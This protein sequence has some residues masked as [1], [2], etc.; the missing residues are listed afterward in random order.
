MNEQNGGAGA[1]DEKGFESSLSARHTSTGGKRARRE[2]GEDGGEREWDMVV[3]PLT[4]CDGGGGKT[5]WQRL[6]DCLRI[7]EIPQHRFA[8]DSPAQF[9]LS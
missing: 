8:N 4:G 7:T 3:I 5:E 1:M 2:K 6:T 9:V